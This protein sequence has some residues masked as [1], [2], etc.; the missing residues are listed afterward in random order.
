ME[1][2]GQKPISYILSSLQL[3][4][5][6][7]SPAN[8]RN[9]PRP[10]SDHCPPTPCPNISMAPYC[11]R[12]TWSMLVVF[13]TPPTYLSCLL[14]QLSPNPAPSHPPS[15]PLEIL[16]FWPRLEE[17]YVMFFPSPH[18]SHPTLPPL[19]GGVGLILL[20]VAHT[21]KLA[22]PRTG[23]S[24]APQLLPYTLP[25]PGW[26]LC[27]EHTRCPENICGIGVELI[28]TIQEFKQLH[29][30]KFP[31]PSC[32][33]LLSKPRG[34]GASTVSRLDW[35]WVQSQLCYLIALSP[36]ACS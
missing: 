15:L 24:L 2:S 4:L 3:P 18:S 34:K 9:S 7:V 29:G 1:R 30:T 33:L 5:K 25:S 10:G 27:F 19:G 14:S 36:L 35:M 13:Q 8:L 32:W 28:F 20:A 21:L 17:S 11:L 6:T 22:W 26:M 12:A 16:P 23:V 31:L